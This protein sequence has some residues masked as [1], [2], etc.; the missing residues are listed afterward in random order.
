MEAFDEEL[1][2]RGAQSGVEIISLKDFEV[3]VTNGSIRSWSVRCD[4]MFFLRFISFRLRVK[5]SIRSLWWAQTPQISLMS[6]RCSCG[7]SLVST[8][9]MSHSNNV[10]L[11][12]THSSLPNQMTSLSSASHLEPQVSHDQTNSFVLTVVFYFIQVSFVGNP[13]GAMLTHRN[14]VSNTAAFIKI[15][16]VNT[17]TC[18]TCDPVRTFTRTVAHLL[19]VPMAARVKSFTAFRVKTTETRRENWSSLQVFLWFD[20][21]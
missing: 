18:F 8:A 6:P 15:T 2:S 13:K 21:N 19:N 3:R 7:R 4:R 12:M 5:P 20:Q 11:W 10:F 14:V 16:K 1:V 9:L 17:H